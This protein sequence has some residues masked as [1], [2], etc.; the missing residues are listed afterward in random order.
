M[1]ELKTAPEE[2]AGSEFDTWPQNTKYPI[3]GAAPWGTITYD[4]E[5]KLVYF[6]TGQAEPWT[7]A[8][9][10]KRTLFSN[11][12]IAADADSGKMRWY[13]QPTN[14]DDW[15]RDAAYESLL[16]DLR[17]GGSVRKTLINTGKMGWGVVLDRETMQLMPS[18]R[19]MKTSLPAGPKRAGR[20][21]IPREGRGTRR[22]GFGK[23]VRGLP[24]RARRAES[25]IAEL[26][27]GHASLLSWNQQR[28]H[29]RDGRADGVSTGHRP[30]RGEPH[31]Q[32]R[33]RLRLRWRVRGVRSGE[34]KTRVDISLARWRGHDRIGAGH[35]RGI[36]FGGTVDRE[37]FALDSATAVCSGEPA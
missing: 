35:G 31:G 23:N 2:P 5:L 37:F 9:A 25:S 27:P 12:L 10:A 11:S 30:E 1:W 8:L 19:R 3:M 17:I 36:V 29:D 28:L 22:R 6:G 33:P 20:S 21:S 4:P 32:A 15:D 18:R 14:Q 7:A 34:E 24:S 16:V 26:Q 13:Y